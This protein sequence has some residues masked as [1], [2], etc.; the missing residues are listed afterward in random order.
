MNEQ[1][2][3]IEIAHEHARTTG[4]QVGAAATFVMLFY[5][6]LATGWPSGPYWLAALFGFFAVRAV[7]Y[8]IVYWAF[9]LAPNLDATDLLTVTEVPSEPAKPTGQPVRPQLPKRDTTNGTTTQVQ[10]VV[11]VAPSYPTFPYPDEVE[12][13]LLDALRGNLNMTLSANRLDTEGIVSRDRRG[14]D[15]S[16]S[17]VLDWL[18]ANGIVRPIGSNQ[19]QFILTEYGEGWVNFPSPTPQQL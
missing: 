3:T 15:F 14:R 2:A 7:T 10:F 8:L 12:G 16:A 18:H 4:W 13:K 19:N 5:H 1:A 17:D 11:P 9:V 6:L